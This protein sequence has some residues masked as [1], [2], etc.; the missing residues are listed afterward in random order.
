MKLFSS[1]FLLEE[2]VK[3]L[4]GLSTQASSQREEIDLKKSN[5]I[6]LIHKRRDLDS[7]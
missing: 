5:S 1:V 6:S 3:G 4:E 7:L 2:D